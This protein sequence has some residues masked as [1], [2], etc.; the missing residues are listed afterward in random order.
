MLLGYTYV[1]TRMFDLTIKDDS[2]SYTQTDKNGFIRYG[3]GVEILL[4]RVWHLRTTIGALS[5]DF[6]DAETNIDVE[7]KIDVSIGIVFQL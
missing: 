7:N 4:T 5:I 1:T 6:G 2:G 3:F